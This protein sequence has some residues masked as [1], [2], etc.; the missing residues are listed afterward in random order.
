MSLFESLLLSFASIWWQR[1][2]FVLL[3]QMGPALWH[4]LCCWMFNCC[5]NHITNMRILLWFRGCRV[6]LAKIALHVWLHL[7][8]IVSI[9]DLSSKRLFTLQFQFAFTI[10]VH[11]M[12]WSTKWKLLY[13]SLEIAGSSWLMTPTQGFIIFIN[14]GYGQV[15]IWL[16]II[17]LLGW[18]SDR[19]IPMF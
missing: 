3:M 18:M 16:M 5:I 4:Q 14:Q 11:S 10:T 2:C 12:L 13:S 9:T 15:N 7:Q 19:F 8:S 1:T 17:R 6:E